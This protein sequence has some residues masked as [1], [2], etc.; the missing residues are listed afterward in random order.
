MADTEV[1]DTFDTAAAPVDWS[2]SGFE[3]FDTFDT[4]AAVVPMAAASLGAVTITFATFPHV[5]QPG[6]FRAVES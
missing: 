2:Y 1:F 6:R 3:V 5:G 4:G